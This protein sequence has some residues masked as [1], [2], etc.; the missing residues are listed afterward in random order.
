MTDVVTG[1][2]TGNN[3]AACVLRCC[4]VRGCSFWVHM[5]FLDWKY[6]WYTRFRRKYT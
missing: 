3:Q 5:R 4:G 2:T 6:S 1:R